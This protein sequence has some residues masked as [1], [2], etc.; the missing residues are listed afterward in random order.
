M[1]GGWNA[2]L[3]PPL[4]SG[5]QGPTKPAETSIRFCVIPIT[6]A[7][8]ALLAVMEIAPGSTPGSWVAGCPS[9]GTSHSEVWS[10]APSSTS[11][12][13]ASYQVSAIGLVMFGP[14]CTGG[15]MDV[16][17]NGLADWPG[18]GLPLSIAASSTSEPEVVCTMAATRTP[19]GAMLRP[20]IL[21]SAGK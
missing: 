5:C 6:R 16:R 10:P 20:R 4:P 3:W 13:S 11:R 18:P 7:F 1:A 14:S 12:S 8:L 21:L 2:G 19:S 9:T 17:W 15:P